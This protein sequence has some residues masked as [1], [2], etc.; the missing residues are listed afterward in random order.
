MKKSD[1]STRQLI[2][3]IAPIVVA[4]ALGRVIVQEIRARHEKPPVQASPAAAAND[5][6]PVKAEADRAK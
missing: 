4:G 6:K 5:T 1:V 2:T 3:L